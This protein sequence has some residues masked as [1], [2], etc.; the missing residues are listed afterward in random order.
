MKMVTG[1]K[2]FVEDLEILVQLNTSV[3]TKCPLNCQQAI[4]KVK[5]EQH[6]RE[7]C[8]KREHVCQH[9]NFK[10]TYKEVVDTQLA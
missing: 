10:A 4:P 8:V 6:V 7:E 1:H 5:V 3:D 2:L 9:C